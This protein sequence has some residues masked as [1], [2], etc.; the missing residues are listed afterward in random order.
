M[1]WVDEKGLLVEVG[2]IGIGCNIDLQNAQLQHGIL[3]WN[4]L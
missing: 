3:F 2:G 1:E 4:A